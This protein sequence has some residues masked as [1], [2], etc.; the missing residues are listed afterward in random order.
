MKENKKD[1]EDHVSSLLSLA[2]NQNSIT[3]ICS[4]QFPLLVSLVGRA[5]WSLLTALCH[6]WSQHYQLQSVSQAQL[7]IRALMIVK[8]D[9][10]SRQRSPVKHEALPRNYMVQVIC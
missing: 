6:C 5:A 1:V 4:S 2:L 9:K 3:Y 10:N 7:V 8:W